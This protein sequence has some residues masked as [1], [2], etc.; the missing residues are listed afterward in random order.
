[1]TTTC[2][3]GS[4][5]GAP[6]RTGGNAAILSHPRRALQARS[7]RVAPATT[8][9]PAPRGRGGQEGKTR[10]SRREPALSGQGGLR[11]VGVVEADNQAGV[12]GAVEGDLQ[13]TGLPA[14]D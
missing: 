6:G 12:L 7:G 14:V 5:P 8:P 1:M 3:L 10:R 2:A 9:G 13:S 11:D 4:C